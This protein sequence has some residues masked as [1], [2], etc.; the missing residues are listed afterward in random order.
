MA[1]L[2]LCSIHYSHRSS[3]QA[4]Y[5]VLG[6]TQHSLILSKP[7]D[8]SH[9]HRF[10]SVMHFSL[11][12]ECLVVYYYKHELN[13]FRK[14]KLMAKKK[15]PNHPKK[16]DRIAVDPIRKIKDIKAILK[17][18]SENPRDHLLFIMGINNGLRAG[19]LIKLGVR[20]SVRS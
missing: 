17:L 9:L 10:L 14:G 7:T 15:N 5:L 4:E 6:K 19:D 18:T 3:T 16:G 2:F 1:L 11:A 12:F 20:L 8:T 13:I